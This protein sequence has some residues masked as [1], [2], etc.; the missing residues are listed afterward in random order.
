MESI[1]TILKNLGVELSEQQ[2]QE[3]MQQV[4]KNY[5]PMEQHQNEM[6]KMQFEHRLDAAITNA[7]GRSAKAIRAMLDLDRLQ[8][9][10]E[11]ENDIAQALDELR[12]DSGYLF[13]EEPDIA[14]YASGTGTGTL[15]GRDA[16]MRAAFGLTDME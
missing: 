5:C 15:P 13:E 6:A 9:S 12:Q 1:E 10:E 4:E 7:H 11:Q 16:A 8:S 2:K 14:L 3:V